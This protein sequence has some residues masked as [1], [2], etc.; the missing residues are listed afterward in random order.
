MALDLEITHLSFRYPGRST[1][2]LSEVSL[3]VP[4]GTCCAVL[5]PTGAGKSTLLAGIAGVLRSHE[6][7]GQFSGAIRIGGERYQPAPDRV[8]F[9]VV[10]LCMQE[11]AVQI[12]GLCDT[13]RDEIQLTLE[14][15]G[16]EPAELAPRV[17][18]VLQALHITS[19]GKRNPATL[20]G[21]ET[22]R[23]ALATILVASPEVLLFDEPATSL[24]QES[25]SILAATIRRIAR[26]STVVLCDASLDLALSCA[27]QVM[28]LD[29]GRIVFSGKRLEF[30]QSLPR[31]RDLLP[32][33][34]WSE[35]IATLGEHI[36][37][38]SSSARRIASRIGIL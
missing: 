3:L 6:P 14:N 15:L 7:Q 27:D 28:V 31:F 25:R 26:R 10:G 9:P 8:L 2:A 35:T 22:Q 30:L 11:P 23:V 37:N 38:G 21:G 12:S 17:D 13:V 5:G 20:S 16:T 24:D 29:S 18:E 4:A 1:P 34:D 32:T 36:Q 19:L 33:A